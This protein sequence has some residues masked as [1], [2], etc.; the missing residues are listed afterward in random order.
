MDSSQLGQSG[1][2]TSEPMSPELAPAR[3]ALGRIEI[4]QDI[5]DRRW[6]LIYP[7]VVAPVS[8]R[9][10]HDQRTDSISA[11]MCQ[12]ADPTDVKNMP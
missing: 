1:R 11:A 2:H 10:I 5:I 3:A 9:R 8:M 4:P 12:I 6:Q 7:M